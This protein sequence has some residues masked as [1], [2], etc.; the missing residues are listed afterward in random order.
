MEISST[1]SILFIISTNLIST[2]FCNVENYLLGG[3]NVDF[4]S[5][6]PY[7]AS[8]RYD[9]SLIHFCSGAIVGDRYIVTTATC[10]LG[11]T[12]DNVYIR[13]GT[14]KLGVDL[15]DELGVVYDVDEI[16]THQNFNNT[17]IMDND[18]ALL[19]T[20]E[21]IKFTQYVQ[22]IYLPDQEYYGNPN[23][24]PTGV[25]VSGWGATEVR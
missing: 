20:S 19:K 16:I 13:V 24:L 23:L 18:V 22:P 4:D 12:T 9:S 3:T 21:M 10:M 11:K 5:I 2:S 14:R 8:I 15:A 25:V 7:Q 6:F 17:G 1:F